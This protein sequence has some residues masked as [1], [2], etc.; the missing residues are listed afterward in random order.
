MDLERFRKKEFF[1]MKRKKSLSDLI[2]NKKICE[3]YIDRLES[4]QD[5]SF[6]QK[7]KLII[8]FS[9]FIELNIRDEFKMKFVEYLK[10]KM[11]EYRLE[12]R[13]DEINRKTRE[14]IGNQKE[15]ELWPI[16]CQHI[17]I[18]YSIWD[19]KASQPQS[20]VKVGKMMKEEFFH[21]DRLIG[22]N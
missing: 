13:F 4:S 9:Q 20:P 5:M 16:N 17:K 21:K 3:E 14:D 18:A 11:E 2:Q 12:E 8:E 1:K 7:R 6:Y 22:I 10:G 19:N 15:R